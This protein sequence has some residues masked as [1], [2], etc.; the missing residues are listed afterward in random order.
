ML[1]LTG[2]AH[3]FPILVTLLG[4]GFVAA[5]WAAT[6]LRD[7]AYRR[8]RHAIACPETNAAVDLLLARD[9]VEER[10]TDVLECGRFS[11]A[12]RVTCTKSCVRLLNEHVLAFE[13]LG[14]TGNSF[15]APA[16]TPQAAAKVGEKERPKWPT[17]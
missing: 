10:W 11:P 16:P 6:A 15:P 4:A 5:L 8:Q 17:A 14:R 12:S 9:L 3:W 7:R 1:G 2:E 13:S